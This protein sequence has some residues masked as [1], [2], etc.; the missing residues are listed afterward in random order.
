MTASDVFTIEPWG[1]R[2]SALE[3]EHLAR[4]ESLFALS[5]GHVGLRGNLEEGEPSGLPG[6]YLNGV[7]CR[8]PRR[9]TAS[10]RTARQPSTSP[11]ARSCAC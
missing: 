10:P 2:E 11:T 4:T 5:N 8:T 9:A 1:L 7:Y 6:T 3:L